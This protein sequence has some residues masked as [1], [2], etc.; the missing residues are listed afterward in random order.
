LPLPVTPSPRTTLPSPAS[1]SVSPFATL[2][3]SVKFIVSK[4]STPP[5]EWPPPRTFSVL[6][7]KASAPGMGVDDES[8]TR[9]P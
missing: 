7:L 8:M 2:A 6:L 4:F 5:A 9:P 3:G 1:S